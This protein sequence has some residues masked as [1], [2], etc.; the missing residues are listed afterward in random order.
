MT[1]DNVMPATGMHAQP[2]P[3]AE[4]SKEAADLSAAFGPLFRAVPM[5][6]LTKIVPAET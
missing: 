6:L 4:S 2:A 1:G 5:E 3:A